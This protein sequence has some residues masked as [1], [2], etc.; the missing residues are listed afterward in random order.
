MFR[1]FPIWF[2]TN[3]LSSVFR[4]NDS[5]EDRARIASTFSP[6]TRYYWLAWLAICLMYILIRL[7]PASIPLYRVSRVQTRGL[8]KSKE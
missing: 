6:T 8:G 3:T 2:S 5:G 4:L 7:N 1:Q